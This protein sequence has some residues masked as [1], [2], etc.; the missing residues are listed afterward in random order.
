MAALAGCG[1]DDIQVYRVAKETPA[2]E[3]QA[4]M[5]VPGH[6]QEQ[7]S[8]PRVQFK[9]PSG[10]QELAPGSMRAAS[11][12]IG[13]KDGQSADIGVIPLP[14]VTGRDLDFVNLWRKQVQLPPA[15]EEDMAKQSEAVA[16]GA[17][18]GKLFD[19][20]SEK[21]IA[22]GKMPTRIV[23]AMLTRDGTSWF[24][25]MTGDDSLVREQ[26]PAFVQ[27]LKSI[28]FQPAA[29]PVQFAKA[30]RALSTN[31]KQTPR[32]NS[33]KPIW[34]VPAGWQE[35]PPGQMLVAKFVIAGDNGAKA[36]LNVGTA[37]GGLL[38]NINRWRGQLG[39]APL[40]EADLEKQVQPLDV[41]GA[42]AM[43]VDMAGADGKTGQKAR[44][45]GAVVPQDG[46][47]WFY[48]LM[49]NEQVVEREKETFTRFVQTIK[50][51]NAP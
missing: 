20:V 34:I 51:P 35:V 31:A 16:I 12:S 26:K 17:D 49:G 7:S 42:K 13:G 46:Q 40:T 9:L 37:G 27:F 50:Y 14:G 44:L 1:R 28:A 22:E 29:E 8:L 39:L 19:M 6:E 10:W 2:A 38:F 21:P 23:I 33:E 25:K 3:P 45:L 24:F 32:E 43:L 11:F 15:T 48:K 41:P 30:P 4:P 5:A 47:T 36:E 18:Q